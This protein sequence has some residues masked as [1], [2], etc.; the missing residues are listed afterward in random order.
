[1]ELDKTTKKLRINTPVTTN[2][3]WN[4]G[5]ELYAPDLV[6]DTHILIDMGKK[7]AV[8]VVISDINIVQRF[9]LD[10]IMF[11]MLKM[12]HFSTLFYQ[13]NAKLLKQCI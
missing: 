4:H 5:M 8:L 1:M 12:L 7:G 10:R 2:E 11:H 13:T 3:S 6:N 9:P